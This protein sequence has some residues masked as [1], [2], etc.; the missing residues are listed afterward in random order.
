MLD[1]KSWSLN[2]PE[3][4]TSYTREEMQNLDS[5]EKERNDFYSNPEKMKIF[6]QVEREGEH[7]QNILFTALVV[8]LP[9]VDLQK[10]EQVEQ[11]VEEVLQLCALHN[12][13]PTLA[14]FALGLKVSTSLLRKLR[15]KGQSY[16]ECYLGVKNG[17]LFGIIE[18]IFGILE[19]DW[20]ESLMSGQ[21]PAAV[22]KF[23]GVN[24]FGYADKHEIVHEQRGSITP[25][26]TKED[27][28]ESIPAEIVED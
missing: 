24:N 28:I 3:K 8:S 12:K 15:Q 26:I 20:E 9:P 21:T 19:T 2:T 16:N 11:R 27:I 4:L 22:G 25:V 7:T 1:L 17:H 10:L 6:T 14:V 18:A 13:R 23:F 5:L